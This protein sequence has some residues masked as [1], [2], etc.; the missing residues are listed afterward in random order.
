MD[1]NWNAW[2]GVG[3][4]T[5]L[6]KARRLSLTTNTAAN[7]YHLVDFSGSNS[8]TSPLCN[9]TQTAVLSE[10]LRLNYRYR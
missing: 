3:Y 7:Y 6:D 4:V 10:E 5:P 1:G 2:L 9:T 8:A